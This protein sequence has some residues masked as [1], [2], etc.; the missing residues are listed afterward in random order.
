[1]AEHF[2][3]VVIG[4][5]AAGASVGYEL[6]RHAKVVLVEQESGLGY[7]ST[8]RSAAVISENYRPL[9]WQT[10]VTAS[11]AFFEHPP[12]GF[13]P[14]PLLRRIG[15]LYFGSAGQTGDL[16]AASDELERRG[17]PCQSMEAAEAAR[18]S[19]TV[20]TERFAT[21]LPPRQ[22]WWRRLSS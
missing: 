19:P 18:L 13:C 8:G 7:H 1:M 5:G 2:D 15:A 12:A 9:G 11:R 14:M 20:R 6:S 4:G 16:R 10:L 21:A 3:C 17:V 22:R